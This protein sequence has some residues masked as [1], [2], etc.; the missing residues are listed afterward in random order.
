MQTVTVNLNNLFNYLVL[1]VSDEPVGCFMNLKE[2]NESYMKTFE[3][4]KKV[5]DPTNI[6]LTFSDIE[7]RSIVE[8][9]SFYSKESLEQTELKC[10]SKSEVVEKYPYWFEEE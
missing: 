8:A 6:V 3:Q 10:Y 7:F 5:D 1:T 2:R 9:V 4:I